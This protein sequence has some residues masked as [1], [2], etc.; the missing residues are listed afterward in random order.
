MIVIEKN[1]IFTQV[2]LELCEHPVL[3]DGFSRT[4]IRLGRV[5]F[6]Y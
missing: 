3:V 1:K 5:K 4:Q 6:L 2:R